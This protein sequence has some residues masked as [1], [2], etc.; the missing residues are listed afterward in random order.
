MGG[1]SDKC[2]FCILFHLKT[3]G[4]YTRLI[5]NVVTGIIRALTFISLAL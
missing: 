4:R 2:A 5:Q 1:N 3:Y